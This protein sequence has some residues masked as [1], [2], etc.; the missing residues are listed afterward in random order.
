MTQFS[1]NGLMT[2]NVKTNKARWSLKFDNYS[3]M[4]YFWQFMLSW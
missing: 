3:A 1:Y 4:T 2:A